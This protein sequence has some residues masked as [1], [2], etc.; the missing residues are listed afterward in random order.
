[1]SRM[2]S[3]LLSDFVGLWRVCGAAVA[4]RWMFKM[5][6]HLREC[7]LRRDLQPADRAM[8]EGPFRLRHRTSG[9]RAMLGGAG[10][11]TAIREIW[12]RDHYL[13]GDLLSLDRTAVEPS[14]WTL[15]P[16]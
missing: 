1:M 3:L 5:A 6:L 10:A 16:T 9:A 4:L 7:I 14:S 2:L 12:V 11:F 13:G 15:A 8:G